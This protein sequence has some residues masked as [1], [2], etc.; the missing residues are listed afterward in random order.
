MDAHLYNTVVNLYVKKK[1]Q[2]KA[3][4]L[5]SLNNITQQSTNNNNS[6]TNDEELGAVSAPIQETV[7]PPDSHPQTSTEQQSFHINASVVGD[8]YLPGATSLQTH[9]LKFPVEREVILQKTGNK[10]CKIPNLNEYMRRA[11]TSVAPDA[12]PK[13]IAWVQQLR[14]GENVNGKPSTLDNVFSKHVTYKAQPRTLYDSSKENDQSS[15]IQSNSPHEIGLA[16]STPEEAPRALKTYQNL[17]EMISNRFSKITTMQPSQAAS[18]SSVSP[19]STLSPQSQLRQHGVYLANTTPQT[20]TEHREFH[21]RTFDSSQPNQSPKPIFKQPQY[22]H[23]NQHGKFP[24]Q[25][26]VETPV[27]KRSYP[28]AEP[29][30]KQAPYPSNQNWGW[31]NNDQKTPQPNFNQDKL[32]RV[33]EYDL[34]QGYAHYPQPPARMPSGQPYRPPLQT[35]PSV[36]MAKPHQSDLKLSQT[37]VIVHPPPCETMERKHPLEQF[38]LAKP[39]MSEQNKEDEPQQE[40]NHINKEYS[41]EKGK[42]RSSDSGRGS[43]AY[44]S[45]KTSTED[46]SLPAADLSPHWPDRVESELRE[47]LRSPNDDAADGGLDPTIKE[48]SSESFSSVSPPLPP[49]SPRSSDDTYG[50]PRLTNGY[51]GKG[52]GTL[53]SGRHKDKRSHKSKSSKLTSSAF[54]IDSMPEE[55][56]SSEDGLDYTDARAIRKQL[57][58]LETMYAHVLKLLGVKKHAMGKYEAS[59]PRLNKRRSCGSISSAP[60]SLSGRIIRVTDRRGGVHR[61]GKVRDMK[62]INKRFQRLESHVVTLARS[63]AH[64]SSEM[65]T[66]H[67]MMQ[68]MEMMRGELAALRIHTTT[69]QTAQNLMSPSTS[70]GVNQKSQNSSTPDRVKRLTKF[71]GDEP[72]LLRLFL[73]KLGYEKYAT[74]FEKERI[75]LLELPF[76]TE[77]RLQKLGIPLGPRLRIL[78]QAHLASPNTLCVL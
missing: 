69:Q 54:D 59:D 32:P 7:A 4:N 19:E 72:P 76:M 16:T 6:T 33:T 12:P 57:E 11:K 17:K 63:V 56:N 26:I 31:N 73:R 10:Q 2:S 42:C 43:T 48:D 52:G 24:Y 35:P 28:P 67:I 39:T 25:G 37:D 75:G 45:V 8:E 15:S 66:Q 70:H 21:P 49:L 44:S 30:V 74:L 34:E 64:L 53:W 61:T 14:N 20:Q 29:G 18:Q 47:I 27:I 51:K 36:H 38:T 77:E 9:S 78:Q 5:E 55:N 71:F 68:E 58:G 60:S 13:Q 41:D 62:S 1:V 23:N 65:R 40:T 50:R 46:T 22:M 3:I